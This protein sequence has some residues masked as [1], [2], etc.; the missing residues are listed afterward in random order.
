MANVIYLP[1]DLMLCFFLTKVLVVSQRSCQTRNNSWKSTLEPT[2]PYIEVTCYSPSNG[3]VTQW[4]YFSGNSLIR[5]YHC[6]MNS[7]G[8]AGST[9]NTQTESMQTLAMLASQQQQECKKL[10][11]K[12]EDCSSVPG[13]CSCIWKCSLCFGDPPFVGSSWKY[14][15]TLFSDKFS[16]NYIT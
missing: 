6:C 14:S 16:S 2:V 4:K 1:G 13:K 12:S 8:S 7:I 3:H 11:I 9:D 5:W 10:V 15:K